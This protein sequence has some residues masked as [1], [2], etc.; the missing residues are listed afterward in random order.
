M[1]RAVVA[2]QY[3]DKGVGVGQRGRLVAQHDQH[4]LRRLAEL[5]HAVGDSGRR[6]DDQH[7]QARG[8]VAEGPHQAQVLGR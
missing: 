6:V 8:Q 1:V 4:V 7:V 5:A 2:T 3:L